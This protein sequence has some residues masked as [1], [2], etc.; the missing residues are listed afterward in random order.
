MRKKIILINGIN[1]NIFLIQSDIA[2]GIKRNNSTANENKSFKLSKRK[3]LTNSSGPT[4]VTPTL[5]PQDITAIPTVARA[6][7]IWSFCQITRDS[8]TMLVFFFQI[9]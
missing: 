7:Q 1:K 4:N 3:C 5:K 9:T 2:H 8:Q 6:T